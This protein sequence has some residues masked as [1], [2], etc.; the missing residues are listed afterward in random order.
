MKKEIEQ[1]GGR[2]SPAHNV[3]LKGK[4]IK[5]LCRA[6]RIKNFKINIPMNG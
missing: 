3:R 4:C 1:R 5:A 6:Q 2:G